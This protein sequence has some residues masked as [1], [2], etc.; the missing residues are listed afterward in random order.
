MARHSVRPEASRNHGGRGQTMAYTPT[1][2]RGWWSNRRAGADQ[3][4]ATPRDGHCARRASAGPSCSAARCENGLSSGMA[5]H[6]FAAVAGAIRLLC[7]GR[8][9]GWETFV[10]TGAAPVLAATGC[11]CP[12]T[13]T[14][15]RDRTRPCRFR[16]SARPHRH[17]RPVHGHRCSR[18]GLC[19]GRRFGGQPRSP[20]GGRPGPGS[21]RIARIGRGL[22]ILTPARP[23][24]AGGRGCAA[25][26]HRLGKAAATAPGILGRARRGAVARAP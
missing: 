20:A 5:K 26:P 4:I 25:G 12:S 14:F 2:R 16:F 8:F 23:A 24:P 19:A 9:S 13:N 3:P 11:A 22:R 10:L 7:L 1:D 15:T 17:T 18:A 6:P 21:W